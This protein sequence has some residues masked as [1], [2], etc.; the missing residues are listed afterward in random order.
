M[1]LL[2]NLRIAAAKEEEA[3]GS[4]GQA[5]HEARGWG[6]ARGVQSRPG[7]GCRVVEVKVRIEGCRN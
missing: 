4:D 5:R 2:A 3:C 1:T 6:R 7:A